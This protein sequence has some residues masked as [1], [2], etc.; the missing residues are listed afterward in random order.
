[1]ITS[2]SRLVLFFV[3]AMS[4][5]WGLPGT[6]IAQ[7]ATHGATG[8]TILAPDEAYGGVSREEWDARWWQWA[9][10]LPE[11]INPNLDVT[12]DACGYG[13][14]GPVFYLPGNFTQ[15]PGVITCVVPEGTAILVSAG[16]SECSTV[17]PPPFF[18][19]NEEELRD[20]AA[21][22][23]DAIVEIS[24]S[25]DGE[26]VAGLEGYRASG[27]LF[28]LTFGEDDIFDVPSGVAL[29]VSDS[30]TFIIAPLAAGEYLIEASTLF[31]GDSEPYTGS[32]RVIVT[33][34]QVIEPDASPEASPA[35]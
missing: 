8:V 28:P 35:A 1:M 20:C 27:P 19:R 29:S 21:A 17:E 31:E 23:T 30:Y 9:V 11:D 7:E 34:P 12:G 10:S 6:S 13:Q 24:A 18:G 15:E 25:I 4:L 32:A 14:S 5:A 2:R 3:V 26:P 33:A 16:G 22:Q